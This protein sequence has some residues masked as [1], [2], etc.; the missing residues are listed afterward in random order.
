MSD[1]HWQRQIYYSRQEQPFHKQGMPLSLK[2]TA[3]SNNALSMNNHNMDNGA[4]SM[5]SAKL[6][7]HN[8]GS[9]RSSMTFQ[10]QHHKHTNKLPRQQLQRQQ[11]REEILNSIQES[12]RNKRYA[13]LIARTKQNYTKQASLSNIL[14]S[15]DDTTTASDETKLMNN[16]YREKL[17][18]QY[19]EDDGH[20]CMYDSGSRISARNIHAIRVHAT[21]QRRNSTG[22]SNSNYLQHGHDDNASIYS[23]NSIGTINTTGSKI[24]LIDNPP[25]FKDD[26]SSGDR[27]DSSSLDA[28]AYDEEHDGDHKEEIEHSFKGVSYENHNSSDLTV[29]SAPFLSTDRISEYNNCKK[30]IGSDDTSLCSMTTKGDDEE[31]FTGR[32]TN[33]NS[34]TIPSGVSESSVIAANPINRSHSSFT[35]IGTNSIKDDEIKKQLH[36][37]DTNIQVNLQ[38]LEHDKQR[39]RS[40]VGD[41]SVISSNKFSNQSV[42]SYSTTKTTATRST[43]RLRA[44][45]MR[46]IKRISNSTTNGDTTLQTKSLSPSSTTSFT[47]TANQYLFSG[48]Y[49]LKYKH[50]DLDIISNLD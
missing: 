14:N 32:N 40:S 30:S 45:P 18:K 7:I 42:I 26:G 38:K 17:K 29:L 34:K 24:Y 28:I 49:R 3:S 27:D 1:H 37:P 13:Q 11:S 2:R 22:R 20:H 10:L 46:R 12:K 21:S 50:S 4:T 6:S 8:T 25:D 36:K 19:T 35:P 39:R 5:S 16:T 33:I 43:T 44:I 41:S 9:R 48:D 23:K 47:N 15:K 31:A